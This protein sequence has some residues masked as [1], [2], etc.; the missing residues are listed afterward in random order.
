MKIFNTQLLFKLLL[1][2]CC[3]YFLSCQT[4]TNTSPQTSQTPTATS[5]SQA[6]STGQETANTTPESTSGTIDNTSGSGGPLSLQTF[7]YTDCKKIVDEDTGCSCSFGMGQAFN[8]PAVFLSDM[9]KNACIKL[10]GQMIALTGVNVDY[11]AELKKQTQAKDWIVL[12]KNGPTLI[13][14]KPANVSDYEGT[15]AFLADALLVMDKMPGEI[16]IKNN[17]EGMAIREIRDMANDALQMAKDR[18]QKGDTEISDKMVYTNDTYEAVLTV[19]A[20]TKYE[21]EANNYEGMMQINSKDG[22]AQVTQKVR[23]TCGC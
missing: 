10:N 3:L 15:V 5:T 17:S 14:G 2:A 19:K 13:F 11:R 8:G 9:D 18:K 21:G 1:L 22:K 12:E 20:I 7:S 4:N 16:P 6:Q 23:G